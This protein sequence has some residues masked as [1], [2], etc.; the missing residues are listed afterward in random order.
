MRFR[1]CNCSPDEMM[2]SRATSVAKML[3]CG[4]PRIRA[5]QLTLPMVFAYIAVNI[6]MAWKRRR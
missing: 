5:T 1:Y 2:A 3:H 4:L 6:D